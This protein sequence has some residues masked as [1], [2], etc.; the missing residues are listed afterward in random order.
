M[1]S[2]A[3]NLVQIGAMGLGVS[4]LVVWINHLKADRSETSSREPDRD[5]A[6]TVPGSDK[7]RGQPALN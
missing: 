3:E 1:H 7:E 2:L 6:E 4:L 5:S